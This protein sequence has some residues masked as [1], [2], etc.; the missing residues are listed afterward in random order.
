MLLQSG[1][2]R[3]IAMLVPS[4]HDETARRKPARGFKAA[5][6]GDVKSVKTF[7]P[8]KRVFHAGGDFP[9]CHA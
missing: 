8:G 9:I 2:E 1:I 6:K 4:V 5:V 7:R 3:G